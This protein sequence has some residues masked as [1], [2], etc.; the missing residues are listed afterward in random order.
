VSQSTPTIGHVVECKQCHATA[1][2]LDGTD[3]HTV[4]VCNCCTQA[5]HH[6]QAAAA[7]VGNNGVGHNGVPCGV[8][9]PGCT[10]CRP[11]VVHAQ[12]VAVLQLPIDN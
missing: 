3:V 5:H 11:I 1:Q 9:V 12:A 6:G 2:V 7:C 10:V 8:G 4:L